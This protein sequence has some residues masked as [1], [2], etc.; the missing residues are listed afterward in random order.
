[1]LGRQLI[2]N[3]CN[4]GVAREMLH[5]GRTVKV[6]RC[7]CIWGIMQHVQDSIKFDLALNGKVHVCQ[8]GHALL[9]NVLTQ[10]VV[11]LLCHV[12]L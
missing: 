4:G 5:P 8:R 11:L 2:G 6:I 9:H 3:F 12:F 1:M 10:L 7:G